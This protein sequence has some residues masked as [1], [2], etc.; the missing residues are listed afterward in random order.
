MRFGLDDDQLALRDLARRALRGAPGS[1]RVAMD[2]PDGW[3]EPIRRALVE[4]VGL[5]ALQVPEAYGGFGLGAVEAVVVAEALGASLACVPALS[6]VGL[7]TPLLLR[8]G[9]AAQQAEW[10]P[11]VAAGALDVA[12][13]WVGEGAGGRLGWG[14]EATAVRASPVPGGYT[15]TG[16]ATQVVDGHE[17]DLVLVVA[18]DPGGELLVAAVPRRRAGL[19]SEALPTLD[20]TRRLARVVLD[21]LHVGGDE[22]LPEGAAGLARALDHGRL[23]LAAELVGVAE[24]SME[25]AV[26]YARVREQFGKP[27]GSF[28]AIKHKCA[29]M[30]VR[31][32]CARSATWHAAWVADH[33]PGG[34]TVAAAMAKAM[35]GDAGFR[36]AAECIQ[37]HGGIGFTWECDAHLYFKRARAAASLLGDGDACRDLVA[38]HV[39]DGGGPWT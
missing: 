11:Q 14:P 22:V 2:R 25:M 13:A 35:A 20:R 33:E 3:D 27:I 19:R 37:V 31:L 7:A 26:G 12:V 34:L 39:L 15:L 21:G 16:S 9:S 36:N 32:E 18:R 24:R 6:T 38:S 5:P 23:F 30:L 28:Q 4:E 8:G 29:D 1:S 17:A 10:L